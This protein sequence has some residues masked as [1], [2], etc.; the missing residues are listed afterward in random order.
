MLRIILSACAVAVIAVSASGVA[1]PVRADVY[2]ND[3]TPRDPNSA[4]IVAMAKEFSSLPAMFGCAE[5]AWGKMSNPTNVTLE[6]VPPGDDVRKWTRLFT[7]TS[8]GLPKPEAEQAA[9]MKKLQDFALRQFS[10]SART[11]ASKLG[12]DAKGAPVTFIE[13]EIGSGDTK[14]HAALGVVRL[15][16]GLGA[17]VQ[18]QS[19]GAR[20]SKDDI[21]K[22]EK[23]VLQ[24]ITN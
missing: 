14:E 19:R 20:L 7:I 5:F 17:L 21:E 2:A 4:A 12:K 24:G 11:L 22:M 8:V 18:V 1:T 15:R 23:Y 10:T 6:F 9:D 13:Y 16:D 3:P